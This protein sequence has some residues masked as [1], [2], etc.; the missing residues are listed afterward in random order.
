MNTAA[1]I[2]KRRWLILLLAALA[3]LIAAGRPLQRAWLGNLLLR[4]DAP[5]ESAVFELLDATRDPFPI[6]FQFWNSG[7]IPQRILAVRYLKQHAAT[8]PALLARATPLI[9]EGTRDPDVSLREL[10]LGILFDTRLPGLRAIALEETRDLDPEI[11]LLGCHYLRRLNRPAIADVIPLLND[12]DLRVAATAASLLRSWS[13]RDFGDRL[14]MATAS[15]E[16]SDLKLL[17]AALGK[18]RE[19]SHTNAARF[20]PPEARSA[21]QP[22][23]FLPPA[24]F[25]LSDLSGKK[26]RLADFRGKIVLVNF[27]ATW[28]SPCLAEIPDLVKLQARHSGQLVILGVCQD[29]AVVDDDHHDGDQPG[30]SPPPVD[31]TEVGKKIKRTAALYSINYPILPDGAAAVG[32][33]FNGGELPTN[34]L[35]DSSGR[36]RRRFVGAR[37]L[38]CLEQF[39]AELQPAPAH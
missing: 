8:Q 2:R 20:P 17:Q 26:V 10:A 30:P 34:V 27:W 6:L 33:R 13:G 15:S 11:R 39:V 7:R 36:I 4:A 38:E 19:W 3:L 21:P 35:I 32:P 14:Y 18:W 24:D 28:C 5:T 1:L 22:I 9:V 23:N 31:H 37:P 29:G 12:S 16:V 25:E